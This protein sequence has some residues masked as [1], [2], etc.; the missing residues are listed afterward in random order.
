MTSGYTGVSKYYVYDLKAKDRVTVHAY[1]T[2]SG[3]Q[4]EADG[5]NIGDMVK[6]HAE[7]PRP[8]EVRRAEAEAK[9]RAQQSGGQGKPLIDIL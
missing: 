9:Y 5:L 6:P 3:A 8:Y 2:R 4:L 7:D 1:L